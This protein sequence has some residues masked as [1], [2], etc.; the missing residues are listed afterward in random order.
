VRTLATSSANTVCDMA[1][2][3]PTVLAV[4]CAICR[5]SAK[6]AQG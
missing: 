6:S 1:T 3:Y 5:L 2:N 4:K